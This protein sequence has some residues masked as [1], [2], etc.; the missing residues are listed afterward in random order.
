MSPRIR[1]ALAAAGVLLSASLSGAP[2][3]LAAG[4]VK[5]GLL[6]CNVG[7]GWGVVLGSSRT[8]DCS[9]TSVRGDRER[10]TG[11][12]TK[13]GVD[14]GYVSSGVIVWAVFAPA[15]TSAQG[16]L[17]GSYAGATG[18]ATVGLGGGAYVLVGGGNNSFTLQPVSIE[19]S[20]GIDV[21][22]GIAA[23]NLVANGRS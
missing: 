6:T 20:E 16:A 14:I 4:D 2:D 19:G 12:I 11:K 5:L 23:M 7:S 1:T 13:I 21:A 3:A 9:F 15:F 10:Y 8:L 17:H 18:G 22:G